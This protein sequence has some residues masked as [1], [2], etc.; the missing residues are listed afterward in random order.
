MG[1]IEETGAAQ[2]LRDARIVPIYEG[3][4]GIQAMDLVGRKVVRDGGAA[5]R[6]LIAELR[7]VDGGAELTAALDALDAATAWLLTAA[8]ADRLAAATPYLTLFASTLGGALLAK[9]AALPDAPTDLP[10]VARHFALSR[11]THAPALAAQAMAGA[12][13]ISAEGAMGAYE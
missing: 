1:Y 11:L 6:S 5:A 10:A 4:N 8:D 7:A 13:A 3:T 2:Y 9:G 12:V